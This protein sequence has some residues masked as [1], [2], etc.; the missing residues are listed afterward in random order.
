MKRKLPK[1]IKV[2]ATK[3][4]VVRKYKRL[5]NIGEVDYKERVIS[6]ATRDARG[7]NL[8]VSEQFEVFWHE[9]IHGILHDMNHKLRDDERFVV[10]FARRLNGAIESAKFK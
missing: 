7:A 6:V 1:Q 2:G 3:Y 8:A 9:V 10:A 5:K 4:A